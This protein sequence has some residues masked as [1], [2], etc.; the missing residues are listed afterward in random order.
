MTEN[1]ICPYPGLRAFNE[2]ESLYFKGREFH[3]EKSI[4]LL[5][6]NKF[7]MLTGASGDGK[8]SMVFAGIVPNARAGFFRGEF[9]RWAIIDFRP[10]RDPFGNFANS[11]ATVLNISSEI[12]KE[13]IKHGFSSLIDL[14]T[15]SELFL[16]KNKPEYLNSDEKEKRKL[17]NKASNLLIIIDQFEELFT[18]T[19]NFLNGQLSNNAK[20]LLNLVIETNRIALEKN[21]P[22]YIICTMRSDYIGNCTFFKGLPELIGTSNYFI[23][24]LN[25]N[26]IYQVIE[27]PAIMNGNS[28]SSRLVQRLLYDL[29]EGMDVLPVLQHSLFRIWK[30]ADQENSSTMDLIHYAKV[31]GM[32]HDELTQADQDDFLDWFDTLP[33]F[34]KE[35]L[36]NPS[37]SNVLDAHANELFET[38]HEYQNS[39]KNEISKSYAQELIKKSFVCLTRLDEGKAV[40]NRATIEEI[41][42]IIDDHSISSISLSRV[43]ENF[44]KQGNTLVR[45]FNLSEIIENN[46]QQLIT[47][48]LDITHEA[49]I[50]NWQKL[51]EWVA[52]ESESASKFH[53]LLVQYSRWKTN[54]EATPYLLSVGQFSFFNEWYKEKKP[55]IAWLQKYLSTYI[56]NSPELCKISDY[57][58]QI[59]IEVEKFLNK[60]QSYINRQRNVMKFAFASIT[61]FFLLAVFGFYYSNKQKNI[62]VEARRVAKA[63]E[64]AIRALMEADRLP[65]LSFGLAKEAYKIYPSVLAKQ[66]LG[67][68]SAGNPFYF[69]FEGHTNTVNYSEFSY[70]DNKVVSVSDDRTIRIWNNN[71]TPLHVLKG[72]NERVLTARFNKTSQYILSASYDKTAKLWDTSGVCLTTYTAH[73]QKVNNAFFSP[74]EKCILTCSDDSTAILWSIEGKQ[75]IKIIHKNAISNAFFTPD[76]INIITASLDNTVKIWD[77]SGNLI[78]TI[79]ASAYEKQIAVLSVDGK[80]LLCNGVN[81]SLILYDLKGNKINELNNLDSYS[82]AACFVDDKSTVITGFKNGLIVIWNLNNN[83]IIK[84]N[85]LPSKIKNVVYNKNIK[86]FIASTDATIVNMYDLNGNML[87][88]LKLPD[89]VY[90]INYSNDGN[91]VLIG[92]YPNVNLVFLN[93]EKSLLIGH[94]DYV[95]ACN[96]SPDGKYFATA[97]Y[98]NTACLWDIKGNLLQILKGHNDALRSI[99]I[100]KDNY[101]IITSSY[102]KTARLWD[103]E[104]NC[105]AVLEHLDKV[106]DAQFSPDGKYIATA[107]LDGSIGW[108]DNKGKLIKVLREHTGPVNCIAFS[109]DNKFFVSGSGDKSLILWNKNGTQVRKFTKLKE[110]IYTIKFSDDSKNIGIGCHEGQILIIDTLTNIISELIGHKDLVSYLEFSS[111]NKSIATSSGDQTAK[112]WDLK[113]NCLHT[114][115]NFTQFV[116]RIYFSKNNQYLL[117]SSD[118]GST[119]IW[120]IKGNIISYYKAMVLIQDAKFSPDETK[121]FSIGANGYIRILP[122]FIDEDYIQKIEKER[123]NF[124]HLTEQDKINYGIINPDEE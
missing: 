111:D 12:V 5:K 122:A 117:T 73:T 24:R 100:S 79:N 7:L 89:L 69:S 115:R 8:S 9:G 84:I 104:G 16:D 59:K 77:L 95:R 21:L 64:L 123:G 10:E 25:R 65:T 90:H 66:A 43:L 47:T 6:Q 42:Q 114:F 88:K 46:P 97:S 107:C 31:G 101:H 92:S 22:I 110:S 45:P 53:D 17:A 44:T 93:I 75:L 99:N 28:I 14:Y 55:S 32:P 86:N 56:L 48:E 74:D 78:S 40:R 103:L 52:E 83:N 23:P 124:R 82:T 20:L 34:K 81:N 91:Y 71:G 87:S 105:I 35:L 112:L 36:K 62:A 76:G 54:S 67:E 2:N 72:H 61:V 98:D 94:T 39:N 1:K 51:N 113:G 60:S 4:E 116:D 102:D 49:L 33:D 30:I 57:K 37:L 29:K 121:I 118:D 120:D 58:E 3:V 38:T 70:D 68:T 18:N 41:S 63:N 108:W 11:I 19:E 109:P 96:F 27:E 50:R 85:K 15:S 119:I 26:E 80:S 13:T 106:N